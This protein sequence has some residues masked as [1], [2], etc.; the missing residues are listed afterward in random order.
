MVTLGIQ[1]GD[2]TWTFRPT[3]GVLVTHSDIG[4]LGMDI[5]GQLSML[6]MDETVILERK[7]N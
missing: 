6:M 4:L 3:G 5:L 2:E 7:G 1:N